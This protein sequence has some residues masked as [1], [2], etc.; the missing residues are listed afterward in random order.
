MEEATII[1]CISV[2]SIGIIAVVIILY[3]DCIW[4]RLRI[5][6][7]RRECWR[8]EALIETGQDQTIRREA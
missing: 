3:G 1:I 8:Q 6:D 4:R 5:C 2:V 7:G